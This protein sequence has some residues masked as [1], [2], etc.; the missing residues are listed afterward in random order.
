MNG[1]S[2]Q[3]RMLGVVM[4]LGAVGACKGRDSLKPAEADAVT[5]KDQY[6]IDSAR[7]D[8]DR[9]AAIAPT[10][11]A[12]SSWH[13]VQLRTSRDSVIQPE[14]VAVYSIEFGT[15]SQVSVVGGCNRGGGTYAVTPPKGL[16]FGPLRTTRAMCPPGSI[17]ARFLADFA[18]MRSYALVGGML[19][20]DLADGGVYQFA[21]QLDVARVISAGDAEPE[22]IFACLDSTGAKTRLFAGF[23]E[24]RPDEVSLRRQKK[25]VVARQVKSGSGVRYE[26]PGVVFWNKGRDATVT[27]YGTHLNCSTTEE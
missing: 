3:L 9:V 8:L 19:Y 1:R 25:S 10:E 4:A 22:L 20:V 16:S 2:A 11:L 6:A 15:D 24:A 5:K 26:A 7:M 14:K 18:Q 23:A 12:G 21:P 13:L 27:W 17:S